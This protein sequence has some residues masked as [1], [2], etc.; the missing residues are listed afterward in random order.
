MFLFAVN[1]E[2]R[3]HIVFLFTIN[4]CVQKSKKVFKKA[5]NNQTPSTAVGTVKTTE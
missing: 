3:E 2:Y 4:S 1:Q 5:L